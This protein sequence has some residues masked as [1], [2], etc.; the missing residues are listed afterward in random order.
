MKKCVYPILV[1]SILFLTSC[2]G[3]ST[4]PCSK[5][6][7]S[8]CL[9]DAYCEDCEQRGVDIETVCGSVLKNNFNS[10]KQQLDLVPELSGS[11]DTLRERYTIS[12][13][14]Q[15]NLFV[16]TSITPATYYMRN[17]KFNLL[18]INDKLIATTTLQPLL[19]TLEFNPTTIP[20]GLSMSKSKAASMAGQLSLPTSLALNAEFKFQGLNYSRDMIQSY[21]DN[22]Y[23]GKV[24]AWNEN[25]EYVESCEEYAYE[26][27]YDFSLFKD[28]MS[29]HEDE[30]LRVVE[31]AYRGSALDQNGI[32]IMDDANPQP[33]AIGTKCMSHVASSLNDGNGYDFLRRKGDNSL[34]MFT[35]MRIYYNKNYVNGPD[36][37]AV[38]GIAHFEQGPSPDISTD[39][40][41]NIVFSKGLLRTMVCSGPMENCVITETRDFMPKNFFVEVLGH[42]SKTN[43]DRQVGIVL[44]NSDLLDLIGTNEMSYAMDCYNNN[45]EF[46]F[47]MLKAAKRLYPTNTALINKLHEFKLLRI[48]LIQLMAE[49]AH[50]E[51]YSFA[52]QSRPSER[53]LKNSET[54]APS[55]K[56]YATMKLD[57][58]TTTPPASKSGADSKAI[59]DI[60]DTD[61]LDGVV[62]IDSVLKKYD[63]QIEAVLLEAKTKGCLDLTVSD[64]D[65]DFGTNGV[66]QN[67]HNYLTINNQSFPDTYTD[68]TI[69]FL[70]DKA[71]CDWTPEMFTTTAITLIP[72]SDYENVYADCNRVTGGDFDDMSV[73]NFKFQFPSACQ[74]LYLFSVWEP[75]TYQDYTESTVTFHQFESLIKKY[76]EAILDCDS[77]IQGQTK[78]A[79]A[80][81]DMNYYDPVTGKV[82]MSKSRSYYDSVGGEYAG[83]E[84]GYALGWLYEGYDDI[85]AIQ[86]QGIDNRDFVCEKTGFFTF[87]NYFAGGSFLKQDFTLCSAGSYASNKTSGTRPV[88]PTL[89]DSENENKINNDINAVAS[90]TGVSTTYFMF[91]KNEKMTFSYDNGDFNQTPVHTTH[92]E[93]FTGDTLS[94]QSPAPDAQMLSLDV[95]KSVP[96][97]G[98]ISI[99]IRGAVSGDIDADTSVN[100]DKRMQYAVDTD[101]CKTLNFSFTPHM[102]FDAFAQA[103]V[104][105]GISGVASISAGVEMGLKF[106]GI[107]FPYTTQLSVSQNNG[108]GDDRP[109][110]YDIEVNA[111]NNLDQE[112]TLL[113]GFFGAFIKVEYIIGSDTYRQTLFSWDGIQFTGNL[114]RVGQNIDN[115]IIPLSVP[116]K[117][118]YGLSQS[119]YQ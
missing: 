69:D 106:I 25:D 63:D 78:K 60:I 13:A 27:F 5:P 97:C 23:T 110:N 103:S 84:F 51:N 26:K 21:V 47:L 111:Y 6:T 3:S 107:R 96:I 20:S 44:S 7:P 91:I 56:D 113:S 88:P 108:T 72:E 87:G 58:N 104:T 4:P 102:D 105:A 109:F 57:E 19:T 32:Y 46:H 38:S 54:L 101:T 90:E 16:P 29:L 62:S 45:F 75:N 81:A 89:T 11:E 36:P 9:D 92:S 42:I 30:P 28:F 118:L 70:F 41:S 77:I 67:A 68:D 43:T 98:I 49:R 2:R 1:M 59:I 15:P 115:T 93:P 35:E 61:I 116:V 95:Q 52:F 100:T 94:Y 12:Y 14:D 53:I 22:L 24:A 85:A 76:P 80:D 48:H 31:Y 17:A 66:G 86:N 33:G 55:E 83:L 99:T 64:A 79:L 117:A 37:L 10:S 112:I 40:F 119:L 65:L 114:D 34:S 18:N 74:D 39:I 50:F 71:L 73:D 82:M 8:Q